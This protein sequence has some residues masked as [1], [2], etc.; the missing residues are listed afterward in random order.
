MSHYPLVASKESVGKEVV[1]VVLPGVGHG[2][3]Y[4]NY[5]H[6][7]HIDPLSCE[8]AQQLMH[9]SRQSLSNLPVISVASRSFVY[10]YTLQGCDRIN[11]AV[12]QIRR[13]VLYIY[14]GCRRG[15][16]KSPICIIFAIEEYRRSK[17]Q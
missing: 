9:L 14:H 11:L 10:L 1:V 4:F 13:L 7:Q 12:V 3:G 5:A 17:D 2:R 15:D 6:S 16:M 8:I